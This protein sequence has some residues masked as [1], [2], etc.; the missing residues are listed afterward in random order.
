MS[1]LLAAFLL[2]LFYILQKLYIILI[3]PELSPLTRLPGPKRPSFL[4][5]CMG[6]I[7]HSKPGVWHEAMVEQ[8]GKTFSYKGYMNTNR[9]CTADTKALHHI[10][11]RPDIYQKPWQIRKGLTRVLGEGEYLIHM[12]FCRLIL[13]FRKRSACR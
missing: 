3:K 13:I 1:Y 5:G 4:W 2:L 6:L 7:S 9:L 11:S 12:L 8:Y 10:L